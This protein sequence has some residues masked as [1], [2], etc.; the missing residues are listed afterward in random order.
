MSSDSESQRDHRRRLG[1][2]W[3]P[4][5]LGLET[6]QGRLLW[7]VVLIYP[8]WLLDEP[9]V[10]ARLHESRIVLL[11]DIRDVT[12]QFGE[13]LG[14]AWI[15]MVLWFVS[16]YARR[17]LVI[18]IIATLVASG[19]TSGAKLLVGRQRPKVA[20]GKTI[21]QGPHWPGAMK[22]DASFPSGHASVAFGFAYGLTRMLPQH[23]RLWLFLATGCGLSRAF[24][25]AHF[26]TD[27]LVG[28]WL[29]WEV[30]R[31]FWESR[32]GR[33]LMNRM[34]HQIPDRPWFPLWNWVTR[35]DAP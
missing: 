2:P 22:P 33:W 11:G 7:L 14:V 8:V 12:R 18:A 28:G 29:G 5:W 25:E 27:V 32:I 6:W 19:V 24:G 1:R 23:R 20:E 3:L 34:D 10:S 30:A 21:L 13:P 17:P 15:S 31:L 35:G 26:L 4:A 16:R 9:L